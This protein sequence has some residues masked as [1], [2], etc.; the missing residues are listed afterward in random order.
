MIT[1]RIAK[2]LIADDHSLFRKGL[3]LALSDLLGVGTV[4]EASSLDEA[5]DQLARQTDVGLVL[6]DLHMPGMDGMDS[7]RALVEGHPDVPV[8][9]VSAAE[10]RD[11]VLAALDAGARGYIPKSLEEK[12]LCHALQE[13]AAGE[14]YVPP[15]LVRRADAPERAKAPSSAPLS[16]DRLTPRQRD[17]LALL[18]Q[19][20]SNKEIARALDI[21]EGTVK[22]HL[23]ALLRILGVRNRTEA[24]ARAVKLQR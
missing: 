5:A 3:A 9:V 13:I 19:G 20:R 11:L 8:V 17:V 6:I 12:A 23:A 16:L 22:I 15:T 7:I 2:A 14:I 10:E 18:A 4:V 1:S 21:A 24:A